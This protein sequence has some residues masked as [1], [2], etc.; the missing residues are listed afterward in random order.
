MTELL[1]ILG[2]VIVTWLCVRYVRQQKEKNIMKKGKLVIEIEKNGDD[3]MAKLEVSDMTMQEVCVAVGTGLNKIL[4]DN[5]DDN[6]GRF[7]MRVQAVRDIACHI[8][9]EKISK[10]MD[11]ALEKAEELIANEKEE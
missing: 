11:S 6:V 7:L 2:I 4:C 3:M 5:T 1:V 10:R 8:G 9:L